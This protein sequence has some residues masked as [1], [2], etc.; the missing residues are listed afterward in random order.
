[1]R[2]EHPEV[3][4]VA[5]VSGKEKVFSAGANIHMLGMSSHC[6]KVNFCKYTNETRLAMEDASA[7]SGQRYLA[8]CSGIAAGGGYE[9]ALACD[10]IL[11]VDDGNSAVSLPEVPLLG[12]LPGT[13]GLTRVVDKRRVR[14]DHADIFCTLAEGV[15]GQRA[16]DWRLVDG[17]APKSRF[18][19]LIRDRLA[20][21][22][23]SAPARSG[24]GVKLTPLNIEA[25]EDRLEYTALT[26]EIDRVGRKATLT[27]RGPEGEPPSDA[28]ALRKMGADAWHLRLSREL[29]DAL[30]RLRF[31]E[32]EIGLLLLKSQGDP[33]RVAQHDAAI[34][35]LAT[36]DWFAREIGLMMARTLRRLD[37]TARSMFALVEPG[38]CFVGSLL[39]VVLAADRAYALNDPERP[40]TMMY[41]ALNF[42]SLPMGHGLSRLHLRRLHDPES[43]PALQKRVESGDAPRLDADAALAAGLLTVAPDDID[44]ADEVRVAIEE[45]ASLSPDAL[46]GMEASLRFP[47]PETSETKIFGRLSAWQNWIFQRPNAVGEKGALHCYGKPVRPAFDWRRT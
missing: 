6:F 8:A 29:E 47:G 21:L 46:T 20:R 15:K 32:E 44:Y 12:V 5:I 30:F 26:V 40:V 39:E 43:L 19:D 3:K 7:H 28:A 35:R 16:V 42:G 18:E 27:F 4:A 11:L 25:S 22:V 24:P 34:A 10:Q 37:V 38:S 31:N 14:R 1:L 17:I 9:L 13:G 23:A 36:E 2:F 45:R 33:D 41:T